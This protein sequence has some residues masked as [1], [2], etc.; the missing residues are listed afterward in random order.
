MI[1]NFYIDGF[2]LYFRALKDTPHRWLDLQRLAEA[3]FPED[4]VHRIC[5]FTARISAR[6]NNPGQ[7]RR[8]QVYLKA[9]ST[10]P[11]CEIQFGRF[12]SGAQWRP[13]ANPIPGVSPYVHVLDSVEKGSDVNLATRLLVDGF[14]GEYE[15]AV[16]ISKDADFAAAMKYVRDGLGLSVT[17]VNPDSDPH[18]TTPRDLVNAATR[19]KRLWK[20][21]L[22]Q[23]QF[24]DSLP[25]EKGLI[26]KP[27]GW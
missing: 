1:T 4:T 2:N 17:L 16:V 23:S 6:P 13:L 5:Y 8:Q 10:L 19:V 27:I 9:L 11:N 21:H 15:Q 18:A 3:L 7:G 26:T 22:R 20:T 12:R 24:P 14:N 25:D